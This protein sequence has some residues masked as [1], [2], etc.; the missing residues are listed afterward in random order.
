MVR[1]VDSIANIG[2]GKLRRAATNGLGNGGTVFLMDPGGG[3]KV[4]AHRF[5]DLFGRLPSMRQGVVS[6]VE[7]SFMM[8][9][10]VFKWFLCTIWLI[11]LVCI[12]TWSCG[13]NLGPS[14]AQDGD[15][16]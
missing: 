15:F 13:F 12:S 8:M 2:G 9:V 3:G 16:W 7:S 4:P 14:E 5:G 6:S 10:V 11:N 1:K